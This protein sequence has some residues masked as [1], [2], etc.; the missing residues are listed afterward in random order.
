MTKQEMLQEIK[1]NVPEVHEAGYSTGKAEGG[2][3]SYQTGF[4]N[5]KQA[6]YD[7]FWDTYQNNGK[8]RDS[9]GMF[10]GI[11]WNK[12]TLKPKYPI[13]VL[14]EYM[15]FAHCGYD[16]DLDDAFEK[17]GVPL[18][19]DL[20]SSGSSAH[21]YLFYN[22]LITAVGTVDISPLTNTSHVSSMFN[23]ASLVT[24]RNLIP[25][26]C[27]MS[28]TCWNS[29]LKNLGI[30]GDITKDFNLSRC[31]K[32][33]VKSLQSVIDHLADLTGA[34]TQTLTF[35]NTVGSKLT[36]AQKQ[37]ITAKNWTLAY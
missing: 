15:M 17:R 12:D 21:G 4:E 14:S 24:I 33:T 37:Q 35:H 18:V 31:S 28:A 16:G 6:Q 3:E 23:S 7:E 13:T 29:E 1:D 19:F 20:D 8:R 11:G 27:A 22:S 32:L 2:A 34:T 5:G 30:G 9:K 10:M 36:D 26:Q 25:P